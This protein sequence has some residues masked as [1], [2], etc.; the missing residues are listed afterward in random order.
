MGANTIWS[1]SQG[2]LAW[3]SVRGDYV[4]SPKLTVA[5]DSFWDLPS[6][7][8]LIRTPEPYLRELVPTCPVCGSDNP[9]PD[10]AYCSSCGSSLQQSSA[11]ST[12]RA[13]PSSANAGYRPQPSQSNSR[14]GATSP[15]DLSQRYDKALRRVEQR[16][17]AILIL[18][19]A[20]VVLVFL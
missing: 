9:Q 4:R 8:A 18:S 15:A 1:D 3:W 19:I 13:Q 12:Y 11:S 20:V 7:S 2:V 17:T 5:A 14:F 10:A 16:G 6:A